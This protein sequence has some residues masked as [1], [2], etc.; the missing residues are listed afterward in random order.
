MPGLRAAV[1]LYVMI[2]A[3]LLG[4]GAA[5][6]LWS[7]SGTA[8][9][10]ATAAPMTPATIGRSITCSR[11]DTTAAYVTMEWGASDAS[12][13]QVT[14]TDKNGVAVVPAAI[15][16]GGVPAT[17]TAVFEGNLNRPADY[18]L[19]ILPFVG[20]PDAPNTWI[21]GQATTWTLSLAK[22]AQRPTATCV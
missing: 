19:G 2:V 8:A 15:V 9:V 20:D 17:H 3:G 13:Y 21:R 10:N 11:Q 16:R 6:A 14:I 1:V 12:G 22:T 18:T 7:Q 4:G 5:F